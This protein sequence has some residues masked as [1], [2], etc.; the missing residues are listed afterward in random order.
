M[1]TTY[2]FN[3]VTVDG[4]FE[5]PKKWVIDW[6]NVDAEFNDF[7]IRQLDATDLLVFGRV[8]YEGMASYW[9][10][11]RAIKNDPMVAGRMNSMAKV[12]ASKTLRKADW[13]NTTLI[14]TGIEREIASLK[15]EPGKEIGIFGSANLAATLINAGLVDEFRII[16]NPVFLGKGTGLFS[17]LQR[18]NLKLL[19][20]TTFES[21]NVLLRYVP[22]PS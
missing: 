20:A 14:Q 7:A 6:H 4:Y 16:V 10:T 1:R 2:L 17:D 3:M 13:N 12:V 21:G 18:T 8:T 5:G 9:P 22:L 19:D 15:R 11:Q